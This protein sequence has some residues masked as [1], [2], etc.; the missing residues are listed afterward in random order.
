MALA[1]QVI[2]TSCRRGM[3][4]AGDGLQV[5]SYDEGLPQAGLDVGVGFH[6]L[7]PFDVPRTPGETVFGYAPVDGCGAVWASNTK[8]AHDYMGPGGRAGNVLRHAIILPFRDLD[9][10]PVEMSGSP[11]FRREMDYGEVNSP[12]P[13]AFL[14]AVEAAPAEAIDERRARWSLTGT[15]EAEA[16]ASLA[17]ATAQVVGEG[18]CVAILADPAEALKW[19]ALATYSLPLELAC[20]V[21]FVVGCDNLATAGAIL[22][23]I[24]P[25]D[26]QQA[27]AYLRDGCLVFDPREGV[28]RDGARAWKT[29]GF[30]DGRDP[31]EVD[32]G[33]FEALVERGWSERPEE[34]DAF[35][36]L[37]QRDL[38]LDLDPA[39][40]D[41]AVDALH[42]TTM[43]LRRLPDPVAV[44][45]FV[46]EHGSDSFKLLFAGGALKELGELDAAATRAAV[47]FVL[48]CW[49]DADARG[50]KHVMGEVTAMLLEDEAASAAFLDALAAG[51]S[52]AE[53][54]GSCGDALLGEAFGGPAS[55]GGARPVFI[56]SSSVSRGC[57]SRADA[58][59]GV[60][61]DGGSTVAGSSCGGVRGKP[62][63]RHDG[64]G[65]EG[66]RLGPTRRHGGNRPLFGG[67]GRLPFGKGRGR[68]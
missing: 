48:G 38:S 53:E 40:L 45:E 62:T 13:P 26:F 12:E 50:R 18:R 68:R 37:A 19:I 17:R 54:D 55:L 64:S 59:E 24:A 58:G 5:F 10:Y 6:R 30:D 2:Y 14:P 27:P 16:A 32:G 21:S 63:L 23:G 3:Q 33:L 47:G 31:R 34:L 49:E 66:R 11:L 39:Q 9:F 60:S 35:R 67:L 15:A 7:L 57:P 42:A 36:R 41:G 51:F 28:V 1:H 52:S 46:A 22:C 61:R 8:L 20:Q 43:G 25:E 4:G 29:G 65:N 56:G 44:L